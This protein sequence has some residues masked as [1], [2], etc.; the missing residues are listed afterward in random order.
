MEIRKPI[1][2]GKFLCYCC[3]YKNTTLTLSDREWE[4]PNCH[5]LLDRDKN[6]ALNILEEGLKILNKSGQGLSVEPIVSEN[7][8]SLE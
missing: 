6:A 1:V 2:N 4:C 5:K 7:I 3:G 8:S